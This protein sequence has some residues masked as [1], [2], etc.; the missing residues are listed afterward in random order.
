MPAATSAAMIVSLRRRIAFL[1]MP[2][3]A[4]TAIE[5]AL[6]PHADIVIS[7]DP[8]LKHM[9]LR[10]YTRFVAPLLAA[11][12]ARPVETLCLIRE[13][14]DWLASWYRYRRREGLSEPGKRTDGMSFAGFVEAWLAAEPPPFARVGRPAE[15]LR[16]RAGGPG[17][18]HLFRYEAIG[19]CE[20][21]LAG[22][23]AAPF[24]FAHL[25]VSPPAGVDLPP[26]LRARAEAALAEDYRLW[27]GAR[28]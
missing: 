25:N 19:A 5:A 11:Y 17:I 16:P 13:P 7:G 24:R 15:F 3:A 23:F 20:A 28:S 6:A 26:A 27:H 9:P 10:R 21:F 2:K 18:D 12:D 4:S 1:A 14:L 22:R 8:R